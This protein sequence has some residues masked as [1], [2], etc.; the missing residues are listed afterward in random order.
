MAKSYTNFIPT[1]WSASLL[2]NLNK[3]LVYANLV[4]RDYQG[5]ITQFGD[6]VK[7]N[8]F[9][10]V[11]ISSYDP[12]TGLSA[13]EK[14]TSY[15]QTLTIDQAKSFNFKADSIEMAQANINIMNNAMERAAYAMA[16]VIDQ[17]IAA[18]Y[19][20]IDTSMMIG[21]DTTPKSVTASNAYDL[22][23]D[24]GVALTEKNVPVTGRWIVIPAW[25]HGLLL[26]DDRFIKYT[27]I[28]QGVMYNGMVGKVSGFDVYVSNNVPNTAGTKYKIMAGTNDAITYAGQVTE[29]DAY[30]PENFFADAIKGLYVY[31]AK[32][33]KDTTDTGSKRIALITANKG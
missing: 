18:F 6:T 21:D 11:T 31:G 4:N 28:G 17:Y 1:L 13:A 2:S 8:Q 25:Y 7:I 12:A 27:D 5:E 16:D 20:G 33:L 29:I 19:T 14:P 22:I 32:L 3:N 26:K 9:G 10:G 30:R 24:A 15:Q 23:V